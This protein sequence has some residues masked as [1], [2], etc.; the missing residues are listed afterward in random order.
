MVIQS[1]NNIGSNGA[2]SAGKTR[3]TATPASK[4]LVEKKQADAPLGDSVSLSSTGQQLA[5]AEASLGQAPD[6]DSAKVDQIRN[7][8]AKGSYQIDPERI[9]DK[10]I[11]QDELLG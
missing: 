1:G 10:M 6:V 9:A 3:Q 8:I 2:D 11:S 7:A 4:G 5:K